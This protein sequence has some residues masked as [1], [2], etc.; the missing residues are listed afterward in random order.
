MYLYPH[1]ENW[2]LEF[3]HEKNSIISASEGKIEIYHIG[4]TAIK[5]L[6]AKD[7]IDL[8]GV[9]KNISDVSTVK[10][11]LVNLGYSYRGENGIPGRQY[12]SKTQRKAH[13]HIFQYG[14]DNIEKHI[15]FVKF[16]QGNLS[17]INE[18]NQIKQKLHAKYPKDKDSYQTEK[19]FFYH[20]INKMLATN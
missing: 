17:L 5:G 11:R 9:V 20:R 6:Y 10:Q 2:Q 4:S 12:F 7:C 3:E 14:D 8:L 13:L 19:A 1:N 18:L 16:M 15:K